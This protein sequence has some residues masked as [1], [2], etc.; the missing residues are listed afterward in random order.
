MVLL[1]IHS[2]NI[3]GREGPSDAPVWAGGDK[4]EGTKSGCAWRR[5]DARARMSL[6]AGAWTSTPMA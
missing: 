5:N 2:A 3:D 6:K 4:R 1:E